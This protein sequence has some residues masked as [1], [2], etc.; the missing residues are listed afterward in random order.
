MTATGVATSYR[1]GVIVRVDERRSWKV[2]SVGQRH[3]NAAVSYRCAEGRGLSAA[4]LV[5]VLRL[6]GRAFDEVL[7]DELLHVRRFGVPAITIAAMLGNIPMP[8]LRAAD[9]FADRVAKVLGDPQN[10]RSA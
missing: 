4:G 5:S 6:L 1:E 10:N 9:E 3:Q 2:G 7:A 8:T